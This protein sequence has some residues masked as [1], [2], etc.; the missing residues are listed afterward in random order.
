MLAGSVDTLVE[1]DMEAGHSIELLVKATNETRPLSKQLTTGQK[2]L[3]GGCRIGYNEEDKIDDFKEAIEAAKAVDVTVVI[4]GLDEEW[5]SE[6]YDRPTMDLP[7]DGSQ[8]RL[9]AEVVAA[10]PNTIVVIQAGSPVT[11][12]W[13]DKVPCILQAWY[14]GQE[15]GNALSDVLFGFVNPSGKLPVG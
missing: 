1:F 12:P 10:N 13:A 8:D 3:S 11:M 9:I 7:K 4:V 6:G 14:Q 5:E 2:Y 15:A